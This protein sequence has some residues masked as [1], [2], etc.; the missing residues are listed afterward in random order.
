MRTIFEDTN[1]KA[2]LEEAPTRGNESKHTLFLLWLLAIVFLTGT[3]AV[4]RWVDNRPALEP[5]PPPVSLD[6][7][8][9]TTEA[10]GKFNRFAKDG[11]WTE[12]E[13]MLSNAA[14]QRLAGE[15]KSLRDSLM[16]QFKDLKIAE[17]STTLSIDRSVPGRVRQDSYFIFTD[18]GLTKTE[19]KIV[20]LVLI[21][22]D[23]RLVIDS[24]SDATLE[25]QKKA[26]G[27]GNPGEKK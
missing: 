5:P 16:G 10:F 25:E 22:E 24:W 18:E 11:N 14:K 2:E 1:L 3:W 27:A 7:P 21:M 19:T 26:E 23:G 17:A 4:Y 15:Q 9:Q 12:A 6:D 20:P 13:A 8:K